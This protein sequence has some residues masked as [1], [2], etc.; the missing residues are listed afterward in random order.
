VRKRLFV[1]DAEKRLFI[2]R[3]LAMILLGFTLSFARSL[4]RVKRAMEA[5]EVVSDVELFLK[6]SRLQ[7]L[8]LAKDKEIIEALERAWSNASYRGKWK[9]I[10]VAEWIRQN[11]TDTLS[12]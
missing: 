5:D 6:A 7:D 9:A 8:V 10:S 1:S 3:I 12:P 11:S 2:T 4:A